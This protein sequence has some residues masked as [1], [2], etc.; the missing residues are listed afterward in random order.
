M[1]IWNPTIA[2]LTIGKKNGS[3]LDRSTHIEYLE[4]HPS[5][6]ALNNSDDW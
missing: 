6:L 3:S 1:D 5:S 2:S 4:D